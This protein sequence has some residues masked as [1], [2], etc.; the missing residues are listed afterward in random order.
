MITIIYRMGVGY[1]MATM[2]EADL[3]T[4]IVLAISIFFL[5]YNLVNLPFRQAFHN[6]RANLCHLTQF[7]CLFIAMYFR[8]MT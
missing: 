4:L 1:Y 7:L 6:Y 3:S 5:L 8:S 2:N